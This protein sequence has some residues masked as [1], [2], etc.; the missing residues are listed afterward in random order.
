MEEDK[1]FEYYSSN[2]LDEEKKKIKIEYRCKTQFCMD[3]SGLPCSFC[4]MA[5]KIQN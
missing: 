5:E 3:D 1:F 2:K 4:W